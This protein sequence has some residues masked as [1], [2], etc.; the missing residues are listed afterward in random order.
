MSP[1]CTHFKS[2][3]AK[4]REIFA[5]SGR[6]KVEW[7]GTLFYEL[8]VHF[9]RAYSS[10]M[11]VFIRLYSQVK[12]EQ[13]IARWAVLEG[14]SIECTWALDRPWRNLV[15]SEAPSSVLSLTCIL[16]RSCPFQSVSLMSP[17]KVYQL[18]ISGGALRPVYK[19]VTKLMPRSMPNLFPPPFHGVEYY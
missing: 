4:R 18:L 7:M 6:C 3:L 10:R 13:N 9:P 14:I 12:W 11:F 15:M 2:A 19:G 17:E 5:A 16:W 8:V 1:Q